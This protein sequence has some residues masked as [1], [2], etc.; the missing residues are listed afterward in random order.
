M[1]DQ[2]FFEIVEGRDN[3][4]FK[5]AYRSTLSRAAFVDAVGRPG[6]RA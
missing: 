3:M 4:Q 2:E 5:P 6:E 1:V